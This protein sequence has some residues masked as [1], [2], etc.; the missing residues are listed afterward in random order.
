MAVLNQL[1]AQLVEKQLT[2]WLARRFPDGA[3]SVTDV[4]IPHGSGG[5]NESVFLTARWRDAVGIDHHERLVARVMPQGPAV[6]PPEHYDL[7]AEFQLLSTLSRDTSLPVPPVH[8]M[9][10]DP[11]VIGSGFVVMSF[12]AGRIPGDDPPFTVGGWV[13]DL[14][15]DE[16]ARLHDNGLR[17]VADL[18]AT[19]W[20]ALGLR[21]S[22]TRPDL[23]SDG[24]D[25]I[26]TFY[27]NFF[28]WAGAGKPNPTLEAARDWLRANRPPDPDR[29]TLCWGDARVGNMIFADDLSVA[30]VLDLETATL[31]AP[32]YD[33]AWWLVLNRHHSAGIGAALPAG[34]PSEQE[35][36]A[37]YEELTGHRVEHMHYYDVLSLQRLSIMMVQVANLMELSGLL[38]PDN[39]MA[40]N[41]PASQLL[42]RSLGLPPPDPGA[43]TSYLGSL[44]PE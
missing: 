41:N 25:Q 20:E 15:P 36:V 16:V 23:G 35:A 3:A 18:H 32:E 26:L 12:V 40:I 2:T 6:F 13:Q 7:H 19:D 8:W 43:A 34:F 4:D 9:E 29:L 21:E 17:A 27:E 38:P 42:A 10:P 5:S 39:T 28:V 31:A 44:N 22:L 30:A 1:D 24:L 33:L 11:A 14:S 37:R